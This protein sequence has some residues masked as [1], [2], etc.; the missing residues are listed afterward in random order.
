MHTKVVICGTYHKDPAGLRR[1]FRE[2]EATG[3]RILSPIAIDFHNIHDE[4]VITSKETD[5]TIDELEKFHIRAMRDADFI[6]LHDPEGH[7]GVSASYELGYANAS[8]I[9]VFCFNN[10]KDEML[11]T[12]VH[13]VHSVFQALETVI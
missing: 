3:C 9:P 5:L 4:I 13:V 7:I 6:W 10:P 11:A 12:R 8:N 2:L 1:I